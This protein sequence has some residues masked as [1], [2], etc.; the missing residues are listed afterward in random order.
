LGV[1]L[2]VLYISSFNRYNNTNLFFSSLLLS[3]QQKLYYDAI[4]LTID[5]ELDA[6][7]K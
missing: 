5:K 7:G 4:G 1:C 2:I 3:S 6:I